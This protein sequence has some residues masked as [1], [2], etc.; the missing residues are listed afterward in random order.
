[1]GETARSA[2][3]GRIGPVLHFRGVKDDAVALA[4]FIATPAGDPA[5]AIEARGD[6]I[7]S[8]RVATLAGHDIH[9]ADLRLPAGTRPTY[10]VDGEVF[11][12]DTRYA[13]D[14]RLAYVSCNGQEHGDLD[15]DTADRNAMWARLGDRHAGTPLNLLL[16]G[17]DQIYADEAKFA[18]PAAAEWPKD[19]PERLAPEEDARLRSA[20]TQAFAERYLALYAQPEFAY[21]AARV[22]SLAMWDDHDICDGWGSL[23]VGALDSDVGRAIFDVARTQFLLFQ[24]GVAPGATSPLCHDATGRSLA[25][26]VDLPGLRIVAPDLRSERRPDRVMGDAGWRATDA[27]LDQSTPERVLV[28][29]SVPALGPRLSLIETWMQRTPWFEKY[30]DDLRDQWQSRAHRAEWRR[31]LHGLSDLRL[32]GRPVTVLSGEIHLATRGTMATPGGPL[33]QLVA[34]GIAHPPPPRGFARALGL[35]ARFGETPLPGQPIRL[36]PLPGQRRI[37][38]DQRNYLLLDRAGDSWTACWDLEN[39]G[40]TPPLA[41]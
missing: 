36:H 37:Y 23:P 11:S 3:S 39:S 17:G 12:V 26:S 2:P 15:R 40:L 14:L 35:L 38:A 31:F 18:H 6:T 22:P 27:M 9:L 34:S 19:M 28:M 16:H 13:G 30:E 10:A 1:M 4:A 5:P 7:T 24:Q 25:W 29:S 41:I 32:S 21:L 20:L 8:R 33:H